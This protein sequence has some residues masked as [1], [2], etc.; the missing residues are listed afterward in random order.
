MTEEQKRIIDALNAHAQFLEL[1]VK[2]LPKVI[3][4]MHDTRERI[5]FDVLRGNCP[6]RVPE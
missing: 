3:S 6:P 4:N 1:V 2:E 5:A